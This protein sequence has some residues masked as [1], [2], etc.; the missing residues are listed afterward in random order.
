MTAQG[1]LAFSE[2]GR[3][4]LAESPAGDL[5]S[6]SVTLPPQGTPLREIER[7]AII[8]ALKM[9]KWVQKDAA[10]LLSISPR[11]L[12]Y[13]IKKLGVEYPPGIRRQGRAPDKTTTSE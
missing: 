1:E 9:S 7:L 12:N 6:A 8:E 2:P 3:L 11:K 5:P 10:E 4:Q 13:K